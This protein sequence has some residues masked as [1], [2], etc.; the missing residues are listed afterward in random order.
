M[1]NSRKPNERQVRAAERL[2]QDVI[3]EMGIY[4]K[5]WEKMPQASKLKVLSI[6]AYTAGKVAE[7]NP[8]TGIMPP[9]N[10]STKMFWDGVFAY[11]ISRYNNMRGIEERRG[12]KKPRKTSNK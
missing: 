5:D 12:I 2:L 11:L 10:T 9:E 8:T 7:N 3:K 4:V 6:A 1:K